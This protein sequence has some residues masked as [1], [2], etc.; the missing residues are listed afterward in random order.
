MSSIGERP[1]TGS[2]GGGGG[3]ANITQVGSTNVNATVSGNG[4]LPVGGWSTKV[5]Q[6]VTTT[7][8]TYTTG[9]VIGGLLTLADVTPNND[10]R[11][12]LQS[13]S[14]N[15]KSNQTI[16]LDVIFF[17]ANPSGSTITN[18]SALAIVTADYDKISEVVHIT[19][20]TALNTTS[21]AQADNLARLLSPTSGSANVYACIVARGSLTSG[22]TS[23]M[24][25]N[26]K[27]ASV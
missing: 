12:L 6:A 19:D 24:T 4:F 18:G 17:N 15:C 21:F 25:L 8:V 26:V 20:W 9:Q 27:T 22:T 2:G 1:T 11:F 3:N 13:V 23:E 7:A 5:A 14:V 16:Q 10:Q